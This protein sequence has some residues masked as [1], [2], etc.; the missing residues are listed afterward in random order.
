MSIAAVALSLELPALVS[1]PKCVS[2]FINCEH[3]RIFTS[4]GRV[5]QKVSKQLQRYENIVQRCHQPACACWKP[6][7]RPR[8]CSFHASSWNRTNV[9]AVKVDLILS[10]QSPPGKIN[11][12]W[13]TDDNPQLA[14]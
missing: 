3:R 8:M 9:A 14:R 4:F 2:R 6:R 13:I 10:H 5:E 12:P 1:H 7:N 11:T